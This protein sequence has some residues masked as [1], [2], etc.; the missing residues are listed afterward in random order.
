MLLRES[1][2]MLSSVVASKKSFLLPIFGLVV[3]FGWSPTKRQ[4]QSSGNTTTPATRAPSSH[5]FFRRGSSQLGGP[6]HTRGAGYSPRGS[7]D[8]VLRLCGAFSGFEQMTSP[9]QPGFPPV[10]VGCL[11]WIRS[12]RSPWHFVIS[13]TWLC[14]SHPLPDSEAQLGNGREAG[15][16]GPGGVQQGGAAQGPPPA[17]PISAGLCHRTTRASESRPPCS[18]PLGRVLG[19]RV[20]PSSVQS[21][22]WA[23]RIPTE[24]PS[25]GAEHL[26]PCSPKRLAA[27]PPFLPSTFPNPELPGRS[28]PASCCPVWGPHTSQRHGGPWPC[29]RHLGPCSSSAASSLDMTRSEQ[30]QP[31]ILR[32]G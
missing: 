9:F 7:R 20:R 31:H 10:E 4:T 19:E 21:P 14:H 18:E 3:P 26:S 29:A 1:C 12:T 22:P 32:E 30:P 2:K 27:S 11:K 17:P 25:G 13:R 5:L 23:P 28:D 24:P 8:P 16:P 6:A 15:V